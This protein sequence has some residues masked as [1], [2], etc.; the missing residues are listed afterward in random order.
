MR[1]ALHGTAS[2][3]N[4]FEGQGRSSSI[5]PMIRALH[6]TRKTS[7]QGQLARRPAGSRVTHER[8][9][10]LSNVCQAEWFLPLHRCPG[11]ACRLSQ[12]S[13]EACSVLQK[14]LNLCLVGYVSKRQVFAFG[15]HGFLSLIRLSNALFLE[16]RR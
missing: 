5:G 3:A 13:G 11:P 14:Y 6:S 12:G 2:P 10:K 9:K 15:S 7:S 4:R 8:S 16:R 1:R